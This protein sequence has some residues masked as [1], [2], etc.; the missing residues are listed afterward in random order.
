M[1]ARSPAAPAVAIEARGKFA[2]EK[3]DDGKSAVDDRNW[4]AEAVCALLP[5]K[6]GTALFYTTGLGDERLC[7]R[8]ASGETKPPAYF[9]RRLLRSDEGETW[10]NATMDGC[11]AKWWLDLKHQRKVGARAIA[12]MTG[13]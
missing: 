12:A 5:F 6:A 4:F 3:T 1:L 2:V 8:Y 13:D 11:E 10:L 9:L 7:Q